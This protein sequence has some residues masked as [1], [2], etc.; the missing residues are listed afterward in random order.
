METTL[1]EKKKLHELEMEM[2]KQLRSIMRMKSNN[3]PVINKGDPNKV[4]CYE[5]NESETFGEVDD[6][7]KRPKKSF[8][9]KDS[10][11]LDFPIN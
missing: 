7:D 3:P 4:Q 1:E 6:F 2:M 5:M 8:S 9:M 10:N 11:Q